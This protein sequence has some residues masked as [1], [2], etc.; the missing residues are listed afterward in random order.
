MIIFLL[1]IWQTSVIGIILFQIIRYSAENL[2]VEI[3]LLM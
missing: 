2:I 3:L 1:L